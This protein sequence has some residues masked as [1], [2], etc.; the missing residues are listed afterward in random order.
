M[1]QLAKIRAN[2]TPAQYFAAENRYKIYDVRDGGAYVDDSHDDT[3]AVQAA[4]NEAFANGG[5]DVVIPD[6]GY[7][8]IINGALQTNVSGI[9]YNSQLYVPSADIYATGRITVVLRGERNP[10]YSYALP[11]LTGSVLKSTLVNNVADAF[12]IRSK[13]ADANFNQFNYNQLIVENLN[14]RVTPDGSHAVTIGGLGFDKAGIAMVR[15]V[16]ILPFNLNLQNSIAPINNCVGIAMPAIDSDDISIV[17]NCIAGGFQSAYKTG[18]HTHLRNTDCYC[19]VNGYEITNNHQI[20]V[21]NIEVHWSI[22]AIYITGAPKIKIESLQTEW[23]NAGKWYDSVYTVLDASNGGI[24][25]IHYNIV[26]A[27]VGFNNAYFSKSGGAKLQCMPIGF[28]TAAEF[29]VT[30]ARDESEGALKDLIAKLV[31]KGII[32]DGTT[33]S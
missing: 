23:I 29:T 2:M 18:D 31:A 26:E 8:C 33:A 21:G 25:E 30:G 14:I 28:Q 7:P 22:N 17:E 12:V 4:I 6:T 32:I 3:V 15:N 27:G 5:G 16:S 19:C 20:V 10:I 1:T 24:G 11:T 13:G 9:N